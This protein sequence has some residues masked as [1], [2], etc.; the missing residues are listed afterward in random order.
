MRSIMR[1]ISSS[2]PYVLYVS[3]SGLSDEIAAFSPEA[4]DAAG[5]I[6]ASFEEGGAGSLDKESE[7]TCSVRC[8]LCSDVSC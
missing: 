5:T 2:L 1:G 6:R 8:A 4:D 7:A 3:S